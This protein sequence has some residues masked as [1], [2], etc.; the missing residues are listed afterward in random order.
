MS[1]DKAIGSVMNQQQ[2]SI[3]NLQPQLAD[4][5]NEVAAIFKALLTSVF[6]GANEET[7]TL[8]VFMAVN[9]LIPQVIPG[10]S[11]EASLT[12]LTAMILKSAPEAKQNQAARTMYSHFSNQFQT[13]IL[14]EE[15]KENRL[16]P[17]INIEFSK[18]LL[19]G[20]QKELENLVSKTIRFTSDIQ[21][22][23]K[24]FT[25]TTTLV[26]QS[27]N[28]S[29][30][31]QCVQSHFETYE[32][33]HDKAID[34]LKLIDATK[35]KINEIK[36]STNSCIHEF[37][38]EN[39]KYT[40]TLTFKFNVIQNNLRGTVERAKY[41]SEN[42]LFHSQN[43]Q[44]PFGVNLQAFPSDISFNESNIHQFLND[45]IGYYTHID[46]FTNEVE[47]F[48]KEVL[49][50][51]ETLTANN[52]NIIEDQ[53]KAKAFPE[54]YDKLYNQCLTVFEKLEENNKKLALMETF[55]ADFFASKLKSL[56]EQENTIMEQSNSLLR[57][58]NNLDK[59]INETP[60]HNLAPISP[61]K[62]E[63]YSN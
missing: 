63:K 22:E 19:I 11:N 46:Q 37:I 62:K 53:E 35:A 61:E 5:K 26:S 38:E 50:K 52:P 25:T 31:K 30:L 54:A 12:N 2:P 10:D 44:Q 33:L 51:R 23:N 47:N 24:K 16:P 9:N 21:E 59:A 41:G 8:A 15:I 14:K 49:F 40:D 58:C 20:F 48:A 28:V 32:K 60:T 13:L 55:I 7:K 43:F 39:K 29:V 4:R 1:F 36:S 57:E 18:D 56:E 27:F 45:N 34:H 17:R 6:V 3:I 42:I